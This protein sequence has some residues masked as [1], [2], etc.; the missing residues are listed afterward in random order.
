M[1][2]PEGSDGS[3]GDVAAIEPA[4]DP[5]IIIVDFHVLVE[6]VAADNLL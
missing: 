2:R 1:D 4:K 3:G 5:F 6:R